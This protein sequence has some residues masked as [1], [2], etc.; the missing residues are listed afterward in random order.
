MK[1]IKTTEVK[2][3]P[4]EE[5][6]CER[7][8]FHCC[9]LDSK[10]MTLKFEDDLDILKMYHHAKTEFACLRHSELLTV[11]EICMTNAKNMK[12]SL[13]VKGQGQMPPP[14]NHL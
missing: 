13:K 4:K 10:P 9:D 5:H 2:L 12:I 8:L 14:S 1:I 11:D 6:T 7:Q 3:C